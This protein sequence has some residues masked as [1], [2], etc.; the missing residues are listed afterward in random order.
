MLP[1]EHAWCIDAED[2]VLDPTWENGHGQVYLG[3]VVDL[4]AVRA[5]RR[6]GTTS[7]LFD[8]FGR[9]PLCRQP[10]APSTTPRA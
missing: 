10:D 2:R 7:A 5:V 9:Y 4:A 3:V 8:W 6:R 1:C